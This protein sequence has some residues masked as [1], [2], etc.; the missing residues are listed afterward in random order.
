MKKKVLL[1]MS[2]GVDSS[3]AAALLL[4]QGY[5]VIGVTFQLWNGAAETA[6]EDAA[7][8][9]KVLGIAH[10]TVDFSESFRTFVLDY[11]VREYQNGR[12][13]NP[14][15]VCNRKIKFGKF[16]ELANE[17]G[18]DLI[19]TGHYARIFPDTSGYYRLGMSAA[20]K[21]DQ[22]YF[23]YHLNQEQLAR[24]LMPLDGM[25][26]TETRTLA[27]KLSLPV[28]N[29][30]DSQDICFVPNGDYLQFLKDYAHLE[31][32]K[33]F[34]RSSDGTILGEHN[35]VAHFTVGQRKGL[36]VTFGK[37][38]FVIGLDAKTNTV[39]LGEKGSEFTK[40]FTAAEMHLIVPSSFHEPKHL[41]CKVRS[42]AP[43]APCTITPLDKSR[44]RIVTDE[45][46]RAVTPG[47]AVVFY[48]N[49]TVFGG[50]VIEDMY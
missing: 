44:V 27:E 5:E 36:G 33:G 41:L 16:L 24:V 35:G 6:S 3:V 14:C 37:P 21:K 12:T 18:A 19:A 43:L 8:V 1:G 40:E 31:N 46:I 7:H 39:Y 10:E 32:K 2:G 15:A 30:P 13:P 49:E 17:R 45:P 38:M 48:E 4:E 34:F 11:F 22:S 28:A 9:A 42:G 20:K 47:Q 29:K 50:A 26:K 25:D 23:L